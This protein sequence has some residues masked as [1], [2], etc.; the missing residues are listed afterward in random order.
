MKLGQKWGFVVIWPAT[1]AEGQGH[2]LG[3]RLAGNFGRFEAGQRSL[4]GPGRRKR[5]EKARQPLPWDIRDVVRELRVEMPLPRITAGN[6][7]ETLRVGD[8]MTALFLGIF[9]NERIKTAFRAQATPER[10][11]RML[12]HQPSV[13]SFSPKNRRMPIRC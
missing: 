4:N 5:A 6:A 3:V 8:G 1:R 2:G 10:T 12:P 9:D 11:P 13:V 7:R